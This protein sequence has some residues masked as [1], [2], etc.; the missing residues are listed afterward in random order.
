MSWKRSW[1]RHGLLDG[2]LLI[3]WFTAWGAVTLHEQGSFGLGGI[4][5]SAS[6]RATLDVKEQW[7]GIYYASQK[8][9]HART[10][11]IPDERDGMPGVSIVDQGRLSFTLLGEPQVLD[12]SSRAFIDADWRLQH[13]AARVTSSS[14]RL[15]WFGHREGDELVITLRTNEGEH[16]KRVKDPGGR[17]LVVGLSPWTAFRGLEV[18]QWGSVPII[19][20][21]ALAPQEI[22]F[23]VRAKEMLDGVEVLVVETD[24]GGT[25]A[26]SWVTPDGEV[27]KEESPLGWEMIRETRRQA[28]SRPSTGLTLDLL[29]TTAVP[30]DRPLV[31]ASA[32][33]RLVWL[34]E[35]LRAEDLGIERVWQQVLPAEVLREFHRVAPSDT[36]TVLE[37]RRPVVPADRPA[38]PP[39]IR[40]YRD[41]SPFIESDHPEL[42]TQARKLVGSLSDPWQ[43]TMVLS[44]WVYQTLTKRL[45]VGLPSALDVL[46]SRSGDCHEHTVLFTALARSVGIPTRMVAGLV[47][48]EGQLYY[49][50]WPEVWVGE[51]IPTDPTLGQLVADVTHLGLIEAETEQLV[52]LGR[53]VGQL[54][55]MVL[56]VTS[57]SMEGS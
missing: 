26:T 35:G 2:C 27:L 5:V 29:S 4:N 56:D 3:I 43:Q 11:V 57:G 54:K 8:I 53:F 7:F 34:I 10:S 9:G 16:T 49:H 39:P 30:I 1:A 23:T 17:M 19:N 42:M 20:P 15:H 40:R 24:M 12:F 45:T 32:L 31:N 22:V 50:A 52:A 36:W 13:F 33:R 37:M 51:W 28:L 21:L 6:L 25:K 55:V 46:H 14:Y 18:G 38:P 41:P 44:Q 48:Y 47:Y